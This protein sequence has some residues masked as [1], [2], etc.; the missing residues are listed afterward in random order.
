MKDNAA[1]QAEHTN[2]DKAVIVTT[3]HTYIPTGIRPLDGDDPLIYSKTLPASPCSFVDPT[4]RTFNSS[5]PPPTYLPLSDL[6]YNQFFDKDTIL[7]GYKIP[8]DG[9]LECIDQQIYEKQKG[10]II[11]LL[12]QAVKG[13][14]QKGGFIRISL[15]VRVFEP[16]STLD[17]IADGWRTAPT[18]LAKAAACNSDPIARMKWVMTFAVSGLYCMVTHLK[19]FNPLLG[20]TL[21]SGFEDGTRVYCEHTSHHP[22][23]TNFLMKGP[24]DM[25]T[26][27]GRY[28]YKVEFGANSIKMRQSGFH[29]ITFADGHTVSFKLPYAKLSG[30]VMGNRAVYYTGEMKFIDKANAIKAALM[31]DCGKSG[32]F[33]SSRKKGCVRDKFD[34]LLYKWNM[35]AKKPNKPK[36][37]SDV[38]D[39]ATPICRVSGSW[40]E[41]IKFA[42]DEYWRIDTVKPAAVWYAKEVLPS[43][44]RYREDLLWLRRGNTPIADAWKKELEVQQRY[45]KAEREK[46]AKIASGK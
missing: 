25:Y 33:F 27:S 19:P 42:E 14:F 12:K 21:E 3:A 6:K 40:L 37:L 36:K 11:D 4:K 39:V 2:E 34:G 10:V 31:F 32:G 9:G 15:P 38:N 35:A 16:R 45:D 20:E 26:M 43:D 46:H 44:W 28:E 22:A 41:N 5:M 24:N 30:A 23:V 1:N 18:Y 13:I 8:E 17:R 7:T 29:N